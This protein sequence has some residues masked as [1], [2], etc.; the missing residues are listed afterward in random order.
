MLTNSIGMKLVW[1][2]AGEFLMG[3]KDQD[4]AERV[5]YV[6][7]SRWRAKGRVT[8]C[9]SRGRSTWGER[10]DVGQ[11]MAFVH[12]THYKVERKTASR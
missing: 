7:P 8:R 4:A 10:G 3:R 12:E 6:D 2:P 1:I 5:P 9:A 11:F